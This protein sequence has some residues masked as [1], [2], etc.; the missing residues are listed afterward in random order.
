MTWFERKKT[1]ASVS[2]SMSRDE[3]L[4][5]SRIL[6]I[7]DQRPDIVDDLK[8]A[9]FS[10]DYEPDIDV[11]KIGLLDKQ[12][13]DLILLDFGNVGKAFGSDEGLDL[14]RHI[15]R[16]NP[17]VV[18]L[19]YTSKALLSNHADFYRISDGVLAKDAG[20]S[21][22]LEKIEEGLRKAHSLD[23][24]WTGLLSVTGI[25]AG[26]RE[27][28]EWQ[29]LLVRGLNKESKMTEFR[30]QVAG[31]LTSEEAKKVGLILLTKAIELAVKGGTR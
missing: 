1:L 30:K 5:R 4:R 21:E 14:L 23:N 18:V 27:D 8:Q 17:A 13:Y 16:V 2:S 19:S 15:K 31:L 7:D 10:V 20:I 29:D 6:V 11:S 24:I 12:I 9:H 25:K 28:Y 3:L 22:S 26:S